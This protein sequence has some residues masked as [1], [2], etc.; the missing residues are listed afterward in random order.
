M[1]HLPESKELR[2][3]KG[4]LGLETKRDEERKST[5]GAPK[6]GEDDLDDLDDLLDDF[7]DD[8]LKKPPGSAA[9]TEQE[10]S[11]KGT[12][13]KQEDGYKTQI[14]ELIK[15]LNISDTDT[16]KQFEQLVKQ[17]EEEH[18]EEGKAASDPGYF[19]KVMRDSVE[20]IKNS[21]K[22]IDE[23]LK[24]DQTSS[25]PDKVLSQ[26]LSGLGEGGDNNLDMSSLLVDM[27]EQLSSREVLYEPMKDLHNKFPDYLEENKSLLP[28]DKLV[29]YRRQHEITS[30]IVGLYEASDYDD[31]NKE[32]RDKVNSL[33]ESLQE[34]GQPPTELVGDVGDFPGFGG[35]SNM[36]DLDFNSKDL[37]PDM[38]KL[39]EEGCKQT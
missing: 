26:L 23:Q 32:K 38:E 4:N 17:F 2:V 10:D 25:K 19:D 16:K 5:S 24:N 12:Q 39:L 18:K 36:N 28:E 33:L 20:R 35:S 3:N 22:N 30:E 15:D 1:S 8:V 11:Q 34:L 37:P 13:D 7:A 31:N 27:L 29:T 14:E 21:G 9:V 6:E